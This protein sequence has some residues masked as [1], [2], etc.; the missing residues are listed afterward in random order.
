MYIRRKVDETPEFLNTTHTRTPIRE[1]FATEKT[2]LVLGDG[3]VAVGTASVYFSIYIPTYATTR[4]HLPPTVGYLV[5][6][7]LALV[8]IVPIPMASQVADR[9]AAPGS[10]FPQPSLCCSPSTRNSS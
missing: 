2:G 7:V 1:T 9:S 10:C 3:L 4:L 8:A 5:S 6:I